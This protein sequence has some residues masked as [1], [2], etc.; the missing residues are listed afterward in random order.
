MFQRRRANFVGTRD[1]H[2]IANVDVVRIL[3]AVAATPVWSPISHR[4]SNSMLARNFAPQFPIELI[5]KDLGYTAQAAGSPSATLMVSATR[6]VFREVS[7]M[8]SARAT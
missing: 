6:G 1:R 7:P 8:D 4:L 3:A 2:L 5:E